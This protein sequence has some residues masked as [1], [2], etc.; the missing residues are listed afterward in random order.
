MEHIDNTDDEALQ[1]G[2]QSC[3]WTAEDTI[4]ALAMHIELDWK[5]LNILSRCTCTFP[6]VL[7][8][9]CIVCERENNI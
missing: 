7:K 3:A 6:N 1:S 2:D 5:E 4:Y 9:R 8:N